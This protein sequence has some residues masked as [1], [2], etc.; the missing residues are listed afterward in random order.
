[1]TVTPSEEIEGPAW[2]LLK[3]LALL[4]PLG[5]E[6]PQD[7]HQLEICSMLQFPARASS[8]ATPGALIPKKL[9]L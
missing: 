3:G 8:V 2:D 1:M 9:Y 5:P 4:L 6:L 7:R